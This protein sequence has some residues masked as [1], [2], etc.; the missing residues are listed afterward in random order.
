MTKKNRLKP[1]LPVK[2][3]LEGTGRVGRPRKYPLLNQTTMQ[4]PSTMLNAKEDLTRPVRFDADVHLPQITIEKSFSKQVAGRLADHNAVILEV[5]NNVHVGMVTVH[6][7][8]CSSGGGICWE[9]VLTSRVLL[10]AGSKYLVCVACEDKSVTFFT[11]GGRK[12]FPSLILNAKASVLDCN[13]HYIMVITQKGRLY[14]WNMQKKCSVIKNET[15]NIVMSESDSI[16]KAQITKEGVPIISLSNN[17]SYSFSPDFGS[18]IWVTS[19]V[20]PLQKQ[21]DH[22]SCIPVSEGSKVVGT[23]AS[24][25]A[26]QEKSGSQASRMYQSANSIHQSS[27]L[28]HLANQV[29]ACLA[30]KSSSEYKFWLLTYIRYLVQEGIEPKLR[31]ICDELLGPGYVKNRKD[32][33]DEHIV[34][35]KKRD[36]LAEILPIIGSNLRFQ[37]LFTEYQDQLLTL[38]Q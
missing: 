28:S 2:R 38:Q 27:T 17:K 21:S 20:D 19:K 33:W 25:Q 6:K 15:L 34:G 30:L 9:Q 10:V 32:N 13:G 26:S 1:T 11:S 23:L 37:R 12:V 31:E 7:L 29:A 22:H 35:L 24:L 18:W 5:E 14:V 3:K 8:K 16:T 36:I 4:S